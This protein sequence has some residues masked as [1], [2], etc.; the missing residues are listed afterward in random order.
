MAALYDD[1]QMAAGNNNLDELYQ[2]ISDLAAKSLQDLSQK[3]T[4][5]PDLVPITRNRPLPSLT[6]AQQLYG[7]GSRSGELMSRS[8]AIHPAFMPSHFEAESS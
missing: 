2:S 5:L 8:E 6:L 3:S 1:F 4:A 7:D